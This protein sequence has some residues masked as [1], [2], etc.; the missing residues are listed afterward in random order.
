MYQQQ[1]CLQGRVE[2][3][4]SGLGLFLGTILDQTLRV[5]DVDIAEVGVNVLVDRAFILLRIQSSASDS[6]P[7]SVL[8]FAGTNP[9]TALILPITYFVA[10][11][12]LLA[13]LRYDC[14]TCTSKLMSPPPVVYAA[15]HILKASV[16]HLT[17]GQ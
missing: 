13:N 10:W 8:V 5:L 17:P 14:I 6:L 15:K 7:C 3:L 11:Y 1:A 16:P 12:I 9:S 4:Q 2:G